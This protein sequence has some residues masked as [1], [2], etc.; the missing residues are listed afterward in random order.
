MR[1]RLLMA[2][3]WPFVFA[4]IIAGGILVYTVIIGTKRLNGKESFDRCFPL[5]LHGMIIILY[6]LLPSVSRQIFDARM[7]KSFDSNDSND[8]HSS[9]LI[10]D[11]SVK[12]DDGDNEYRSVTQVFWVLFS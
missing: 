6:L 8:S 3:G 5:S 4:T 7:C 10:A 1:E 9:Y 11:W 12:C 2:A